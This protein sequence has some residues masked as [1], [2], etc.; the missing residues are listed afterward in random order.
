M[1]LALFGFRKPDMSMVTDARA[2]LTTISP[3]LLLQFENWL[4][5]AASINWHSYLLSDFHI[6]SAEA[7]SNSC[8]GCDRWWSDMA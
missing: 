2:G 4:I 3:E 6:T 8:P 5:Q 7:R 1:L